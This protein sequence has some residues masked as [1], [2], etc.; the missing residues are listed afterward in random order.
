MF[1]IY[2]FYIILSETQQHER[3][4]RA[5]VERQLAHRHLEIQQMKSGWENALKQ[6]ALQMTGK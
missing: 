4:Q 3:Q 5:E 2:V 6:Q 1:F